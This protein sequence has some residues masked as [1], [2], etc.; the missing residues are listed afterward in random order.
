[1]AAA[2]TLPLYLDE[3]RATLVAQ[4]ALVQQQQQSSIPAHQLAQR[5]VALVAW[6]G[7]V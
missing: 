3:S 4:V 2:L 6:R 7:V 1:M 5:G